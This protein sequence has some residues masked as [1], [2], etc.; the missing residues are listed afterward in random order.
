[1]GAILKVKKLTTFAESIIVVVFVAVALTAV[2]LFLP[3]H[4]AT[5]TEASVTWSPSDSTAAAATASTGAPAPTGAPDSTLYNQVPAVATGGVETTTSVRRVDTAK[6]MA[7]STKTKT[8]VKK[9]PTDR[10]NLNVNF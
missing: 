9:K 1:M 2:V 10:E 5:P 4:S 3:K 7:K 8:S 6:S